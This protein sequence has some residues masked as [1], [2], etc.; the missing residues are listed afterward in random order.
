[1]VNFCANTN[2]GKPLLY[3]REGRIFL[4]EVATGI[5]DS[6]GIPAHHLEHFWLCGGCSEKLSLTQDAAG[7]RVVRKLPSICERRDGEPED[8]EDI[9]AGLPF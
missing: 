3:L 5:R 6:N 4:F 7:I 1:M 9:A 2:C 8:A